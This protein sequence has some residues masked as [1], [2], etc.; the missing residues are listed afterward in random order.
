MVEKSEWISI[1][2]RCKKGRKGVYKHTTERKLR[3]GH[4]DTHLKPQKTTEEEQ[5][6]IL[7]FGS[8]FYLYS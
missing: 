5:R 4:C 6:R 8:K 1:A 7:C 2:A 3:H